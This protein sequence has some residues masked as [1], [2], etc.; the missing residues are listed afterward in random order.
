MPQ[1]FPWFFFN[2]W[3]RKSSVT[4]TLITNKKK[5]KENSWKRCAD[6]SKLVYQAGMY[7]ILWNKN[8]NPIL[9]NDSIQRSDWINQI[10]FEDS[11]VGANL[12]K[13]R[14]SRPWK[15]DGMYLIWIKVDLNP[16]DSGLWWFSN[17]VILLRAICFSWDSRY[18]DR[19]ELT[20]WIL[21]PFELF[22]LVF[23]KYLSACKQS[24]LLSWVDF[25]DCHSWKTSKND[26]S[27]LE[28][29]KKNISSDL[30]KQNSY[31]GLGKV[32]FQSDQT[33]AASWSGNTC[34]PSNQLIITLI[35]LLF[36][37]W[38]LFLTILL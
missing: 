28:L 12:S 34:Q 29:M 10:M 9:C 6:K 26:K 1:Q 33:T 38:R 4:S 3:T 31:I 37:V 23:F 2:N 22:S 8:W 36:G 17:K 5:P 35:W 21:N 16:F 15:L 30:T 11:V 27:R 19:E 25:I 7:F 18:R 13:F 24:S 20:I 14:L 32:G